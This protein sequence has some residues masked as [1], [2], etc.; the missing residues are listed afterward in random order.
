M[1][2][3]GMP[4]WTAERLGEL[5]ALYADSVGKGFRSHEQVSADI[6]EP[7]AVS[8]GGAWDDPANKRF[9]ESVTNRLTKN[10]LT[11]VAS[12]ALGGG[13]FDTAVLRRS[14]AGFPLVGRPGGDEGLGGELFDDRLYRRLGETGLDA[15][16]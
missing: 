1:Q 3:A 15:A 9:L 4:A 16:T 14:G 6:D 12:A 10:D 8:K 5:F 7:L 2:D 11:E 13:T